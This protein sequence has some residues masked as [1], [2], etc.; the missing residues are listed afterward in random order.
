MTRLVLLALGLTMIFLGDCGIWYEAFNM[1]HIN[2]EVQQ[3]NR[4]CDAHPL[5]KRCL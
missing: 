3:L 5:N 2:A 4:F 1:M